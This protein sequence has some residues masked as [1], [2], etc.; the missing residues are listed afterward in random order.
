MCVTAI[1]ALGIGANTAIFSIVDAVLIRPLPYTAADRLVRVQARS[2][3]NPT[4]GISAQEYFPWRLRTDLFEKTV[5]FVKDIL[6]VT[7]AGD[8]D[9]VAVLRAS[10]DLLPLLGTRAGL[11]R[12]LV[13][14]DDGANVA[15]ISDR[16][17]HRR[18]RG[19]PGVV[20]RPVTLSDEIFTVV[21]VMPPQFDFPESII[22]IWVPL[23]LAPAATTRVQVVAR[24]QQGRTPLQ[25]QAAMESIAQRMEQADPQKNAG[26]KIEVLPWHDTLQRQYELTLIFVLIAVGLVLLIACADAGGLLLSRAVQRQK[27]IA[28]RASLGAG[29]WRVVRQLLTESM[30]IAAL[31]SVAGL[32]AAHFVL[33]YLTSRIAALPIVLP[34]LQRVALDGRVLVL[35]IALC[36]LIA[37]LC[38][39]APVLMLRRTDFQ[40][41]LRGGSASD[42]AGSRRM[43]SFLIA[44]EAAFAFLLLVGSGLMID[45]LIRL[46]Q[47]DHGFKSDHV[48]TMRVPVGS[49]TQ[50]RP[51]KYDTRTRQIAYY[52]ELMQHL[53]R[54]P[55]IGAIA[56]VN[57]LPLSGVNT[58]TVSKGPDGETVVT[59]TRTISPQYFAAM[60][61]RLLAG[62]TFTEADQE[63]APRV[64]IVNEFLARQLF[65]GRDSIGQTLPG[66]EAQSRTTIVGVVKDS[67][68]MSYDQPVKGEIYAPY[69][70]YIFGAFMSTVVVR[71]AGDPLNVAGLVQKEIWAIDPNQ[72]ITKIETMDDVVADAIWRPRFSAWIF[73]VLGMLAV[74]LTAA[75]IYAV[76]AYTTTLRVREVGIR[77]ALGAN[78]RDI[79]AL[80]L[81]DAFIPLSGGLAVGA[82]AALATSRALSSILY[83]SR[84]SDPS[85]YVAAAAVMIAIGALAAIRP[86]WK[87]ARLEPLKA[88]RLD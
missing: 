23:R 43:F 60:G 49:L 85:A 27:E 30:T 39:I 59:S 72:P 36:I 58:T 10:A 74:S 88:L 38:T 84:G 64:A 67:A 83:E 81:R 26:L 12:A 46:Q 3:R 33:K 29:F 22:D 55:G 25:V 65:H 62:R 41:V 17:W 8:P 56:V 16:L 11:G 79:M 34:H 35:T 86:A 69:T 2:A 5:P 73:S 15:V 71:T 47:A 42:R 53:E 24:L 68:Q 44:T 76:I 18:F 31:G 1:L 82:V 45:S 63:N 75:G 9:Q 14:S 50:P 51:A 54:I 61:I 87:T 52:R 66:E 7:G 40:S 37:C 19:D 80:V 20:G 57:N 32:A 13:E 78:P 21:G 6:T 28:I 70:Q 48:L 77:M 4:I